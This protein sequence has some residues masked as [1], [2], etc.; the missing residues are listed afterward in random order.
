MP[1]QT[2]IIAGGLSA[3][4]LIVMIF[5]SIHANNA[6]NSSLSNALAEAKSTAEKQSAELDVLSNKLNEAEARIRELTEE[7]EAATKTQHS[8]QDE[9]RRAL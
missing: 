8:L 4:V 2:W 3:V 1:K 9:M 5:A 6:A 7:K